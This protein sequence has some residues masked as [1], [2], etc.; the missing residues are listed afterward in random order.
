MSDII[1]DARKV[2]H[3]RVENIGG[4]PSSKI[5]EQLKEKFKKR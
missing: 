5:I 4:T 3:Q 2:A 1:E